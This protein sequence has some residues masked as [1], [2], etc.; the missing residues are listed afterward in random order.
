MEHLLCTQVILLYALFFRN[1]I[2]K[3]KIMIENLIN[4]ESRLKTFNE[5]LNCE[6]YKI[7]FKSNDIEELFGFYLNYSFYYV[8]IKSFFCSPFI[9]VIKYSIF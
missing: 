6:Y 2:K 5:F 1:G 9:Y 7:N 8:L 4:I 3:Q